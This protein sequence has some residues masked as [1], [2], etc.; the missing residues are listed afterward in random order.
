MNA[1]TPEQLDT[2]RHML[3]IND[4]YV[5]E[6][7]PY[8]DY[9]AAPIGDLI[10]WQMANAG[11]VERYAMRGPYE[12]YRTT[13]AG[14]AAAVESHKRI[15]APKGKR[16]YVKFLSVRDCC[17]DLTFREFLTDPEFREARKDA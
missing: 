7:A 5:A 15:R 13:P 3:G 17:P 4:L 12:W 1:P 16:L 10:L 11:L 6:P 14:R 9:Y 2:L 8:R